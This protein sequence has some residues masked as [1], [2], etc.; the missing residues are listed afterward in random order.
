MLAEETCFILLR[1]CSF[2]KKNLFILFE[3][4]KSVFLVK[5]QISKNTNKILIK[6]EKKTPLKCKIY[7]VV[8]VILMTMNVI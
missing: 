1:Q 2:F 5:L 4:K 6:C 3:E 7:I 8:K